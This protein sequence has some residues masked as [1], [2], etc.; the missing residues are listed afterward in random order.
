M[1][2]IEEQLEAIRNS[3]DEVDK[4]LLELLS[5]RARLNQ[6]VARVKAEGGEQRNFYRPDREA[7]LRRALVD[8]NPGPLPDEEV[9]RLFLEIV[10]ACRSLQN[11][12]RVAFLGPEGTFT[13]A[14]V[15]SHFGHSVDTVPVGTI[16]AVFREVDSGASHFGVVPVENS[17]EGVVNHT[18]DMFVRSNLAIN[19]E[20][21]LRIHHQLLSNETEV[22]KVTRI[23]S[24]QQ[25][26][27]QCRR[28]LLANCANVELQAVNSNAEA[29]RRAA[30]EAGTAAIAGKVAGEAYDL[31]TL[32]SNIEDEPD[33][34]TRFLVIGSWAADA[35]GCDKT[36]LLLAAPNRP[37]SLY[38]LL[39]P[40]S[41][42]GVSMTRI[43]SRPSRMGV[44]DYVFF[45]DVEGHRSD[46]PVAN[47]LAQI[48]QHA[49]LLK[50]LG[51]Y[52]RAT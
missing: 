8:A 30:G 13:E 32:A 29:A 19:G 34:T 3:I 44:W 21:Q 16:G 18:L 23:Y 27:A 46:P 51:S 28:W 41:E 11:P 42:H 47:A 17:T 40:F 43:E 12:L 49:S 4:R 48:E 15:H 25:S 9:S 52:P 2:S 26:L 39:K 35:S 36:S 24:H 50:V 38:A 6:E 7:S 20:V 14:A 37:G 33:N 10:S 1:S 45:V 22:D 31:N 5:E